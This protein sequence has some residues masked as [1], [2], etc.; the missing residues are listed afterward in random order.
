MLNNLKANNLSNVATSL[1]ISDNKT[2][3]QLGNL[4]NLSNTTVSDA[5]NG[6]L[7]IKFVKVVGYEDSAGGRRSA[8][9][10][11][12]ENYGQII[13]III[14]KKCIVGVITDM[15]GDILHYQEFEIKKNEKII[16]QL[17]DSLTKLKNNK[18]CKN[19]IAIGIGLDGKIDNKNQI[20]VECQELNWNN[21]HLKEIV[22]RRLSIPT[23][24]DHLANSLVFMELVKWKE[25]NNDDFLIILNNDVIKSS[26]YI[27]NNILRGNNNY[28]GKKSLETNKKILDLAMFMDIKDII[29]CN[30]NN[31]KRINFEHEALN[32]NTVTKKLNEGD[33]AEGMA[34]QA[35]ALWFKSIYFLLG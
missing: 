30:L 22:E 9:Y 1:F 2:K 4:T 14:S 10:S 29:I 16:N 19:L 7:K 8:V 21:V 13:G 3:L 33:V 35:E 28:F 34:I 20:V 23:Y 6:M 27:D 15:H 17:L 26:V 24:V 31:K 5:I 11:I 12:N 32:I 25:I 18:I